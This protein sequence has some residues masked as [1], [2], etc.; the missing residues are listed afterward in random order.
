MLK[1][2]NPKFLRSVFSKFRHFERILKTGG[3]SENARNMEAYFGAEIPSA[4]AFETIFHCQ[5]KNE[6]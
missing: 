4:S 3:K 5:A 2:L 6:F 1:I